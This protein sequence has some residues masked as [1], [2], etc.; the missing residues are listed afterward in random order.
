M[1]W[2]TKAWVWI[3]ANLVPSSSHK[4]HSTHEIRIRKMETKA[5]IV[6]VRFRMLKSSL[7]RVVQTQ[8]TVWSSQRKP[9]QKELASSTSSSW[10]KQWSEQK[11]Q[12]SSVRVSLMSTTLK[13]MTST[14]TR[15]HLISISSKSKIV[16]MRTTMRC[17]LLSQSLGNRLKNWW[18]IWPTKWL[19]ERRNLSRMKHLQLQ[20]QLKMRRKILAKMRKGH[21]KK[22]LRNNQW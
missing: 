12:I 7:M 2:T 1:I 19:S 13:L 8:T 9:R 14:L 22:N 5:M 10:N 18:I 16:R 20:K 11:W 17:L 6:V 21:K 15:M 4:A 3:R